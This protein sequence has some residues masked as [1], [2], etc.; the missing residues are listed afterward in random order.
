LRLGAALAAAAALALAG[1]CSH[2]PHTV[3]AQQLPQDHLFPS[4]ADAALVAAEADAVFAMSEAMRR[5][6]E[7][8]LADPSIWRDRRQTLID[9]LYT[10]SKLQLTYDSEATRTAAEAFDARAGN[11]LSLV[12]MTAAFAKYLDVPV[13]YQQVV[14]DEQFNRSGDL[15]LVNSHIN[16]TLGR[17]GVALRGDDAHWLTIDFLPQ[18]E[19]RG[20]RSFPIDERTVV[21]MFLNN[22]A[23]EALTRGETGRAYWWARAALQRDAQYAPA[24]NTLAVIYQRAG[25]NEPAERALRYVIERDPHGANAWSNLVRLL[26]AQ[27]RHDEARQAA[28][29]LARLEPYPPFHFFEQARAALQQGDAAK[30]RELLQRELRQQPLQHEVHFWLALTHLMLGETRPAMRHL[31]LASENSP[32]R[33][34]Q[35]LYAA[36]LERLR[37][38]RQQ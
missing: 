9:A 27:G 6:A 24:A 31:Q 16:V 4:A 32:T 28:E 36:K 21:A 38:T 15:F 25:H 14:V 19:L 37:L 2:A 26:R 5:Y 17:H 3:A 1:G 34:T 33:Q 7:R 13:G 12:L 22:R 11:C 30:A 10:K 8:I 35:A 18:A 20:Q 23:A 29:R